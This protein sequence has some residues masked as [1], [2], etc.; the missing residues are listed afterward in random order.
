MEKPPVI[1]PVKSGRPQ[2][3]WRSALWLLLP[4]GLVAAAGPMRLE[5]SFVTTPN[6]RVSVT[7]LRGQV[8]VKGWDKA[9][10]RAVSGT[11][12]GRVEIDAEA[13]PSSG[14]AARIQFRT[15]ALDPMVTEDEET[16]DYTL[17]VPVGA[18]I[19]IRNRQGRVLIER[20]Q[21]DTWVESAG[22]VI[23]ITE[24][25]GRINARTL[26]G[27]IEI[28]HPS[29]H[30][31]ASSITGSLRFTNPESARIRANTNSGKIVYEGSFAPMGE[32]ILSTYSGDI[33]LLSPPEASFDLNAKTVKGKLDNTFVLQ[34]KRHAPSPALPGTSLLGTH[35]TGT[36]SVEL[37]SFSGTIRVRPRH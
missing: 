34:P 14:P 19:E 6:P 37:T 1:Y 32:Y 30:V 22:G 24:A 15:H 16:T 9:Q 21:G 33:D 20:I 3:S 10:V 7:N 18:S 26:G 8:V 36:A 12:S 27:D 35:N 17:D 29:G 2:V 13:V 28:I 5:K 31:E 11:A 25:S 23:Q 4:L